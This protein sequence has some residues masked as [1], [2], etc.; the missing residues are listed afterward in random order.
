MPW[1]AWLLGFVLLAI[2]VVATWW[3]A[4]H[5]TTRGRRRALAAAAHGRAME[6]LAPD[7]LTRRGFTLLESQAERRYPFTVDG[8]THHAALRADHVVERDGARYVVEVKTGDAAK[9]TRRAT[10]RQLLEYA[11]F[12]D[13]TAVLLLDA[14]RDR[15]T[16]VTFPLD[17]AEE[18]PDDAEDDPAASPPARARRPRTGLAFL[19][20][21][22]VGIGAAVALWWVAR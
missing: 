7:L 2:A 1:T 18:A 6:A 8:E 13:V 19:A 20:G 15:L 9:P 21:L 11:L 16:E 17:E 12:Y 5:R 4:V 3:V 10:R 22:L 14:D